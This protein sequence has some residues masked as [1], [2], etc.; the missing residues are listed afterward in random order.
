[1]SVDLLVVTSDHHCGSTVALCPPHGVT[2]DDGGHYTPSLAQQW[3]AQCWG[4]FW[5]DIARVR[6]SLGARL[7]VV[8]NGDAVE[9]DHHGTS[10]I[11]S[12]NPLVEAEIVRDVFAT[13][14]SLG[15]EAVF[16]VRG[17]ES[18]VGASGKAEEALARHLG[19]EGD[20][21]AGTASW[22]HLRMELQGVRIDCAH[23]GRIGQRPWTKQNAVQA[24]A[25]EIFYEHAARGRTHPQLAFR[26]HFHQFCDSYLAHPTRAIQTPAW[27]LKTA[28]VHKKHAE[29]IA[30]IGG[31]MAVIRDGRVADVRP[32][33]YT[34]KEASV[35]KP[36]G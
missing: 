14:M 26:S 36:R 25:A 4:D 24:L 5:D 10:Q 28:Y 9:G 27:Q 30:D 22:W 33:L 16:V 6:D 8:F 7:S 1:M 18:H 19:A 21:D 11:I 3:V 34:P 13:P 35:W 17:T 31:V 32:I 29:S 23:H 12:R 20:P 15:P 2:L